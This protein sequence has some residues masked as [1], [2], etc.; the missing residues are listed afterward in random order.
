MKTF[1]WG[2][3]S[4][5]WKRLF[6]T[7]SLIILFFF[8]INLV[9]NSNDDDVL[10]PL[11]I[12]LISIPILSYVIEP[13]ILEKRKRSDPKLN[14]DNS[15]SQVKN[16]DE[17]VVIPVSEKSDLDKQI[18]YSSQVD[19][20]VSIK[21]SWVSKFFTF[22]SEYLSGLS[23][24]NRMFLGFFTILLFG[25]GF[26]IILT[27]VYKRSKSLGF[28]NNLSI[29]NCVVIL[30]S[31]IFSYIISFIERSNTEVSNDLFFQYV[32][33]QLVLGVP[34]M[35]LLFKNGLKDKYGN[36]RL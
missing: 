7:L 27:S 17:I 35:V 1:F 4:K 26:Y 16:S 22:D 3:F 12:I 9:F 19:E 20:K 11:F 32:F 14:D 10:V 25:V 23:Y 5:P 29:I 30:S 15:F 13:F 21:R 8:S 6:R 18:T 31:F 24:L 33:I 28:N 34:H 2:F 36:F